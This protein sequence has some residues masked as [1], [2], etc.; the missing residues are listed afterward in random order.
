MIIWYE[1][2]ATH[3]CSVY[4][5]LPWHLDDRLH[6]RCS[7]L[8]WRGC[9]GAAGSSRLLCRSG[10]GACTGCRRLL[11]GAHG[12]LQLDVY[13]RNTL[14]RVLGHGRQEPWQERGIRESSVQR[15]NGCD[16]Y[17][18]TY[19][20]MV[21]I[22]TCKCFFYIIQEASIHIYTC[23]YDILHASWHEQIFVQCLECTPW[24]V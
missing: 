9:R 17:I 7:S 16:M 2:A 3:Q 10:R 1:R 24:Y 8:L 20:Y 6:S 11:R 14:P 18:Y 21:D 4:C 23:I 13:D 19:V 15:P 12:R 22:Y 5:P